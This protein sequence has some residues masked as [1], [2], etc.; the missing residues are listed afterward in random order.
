[1]YGCGSTFGDSADNH[2]V[3]RS[4]RYADIMGPAAEQPKGRVLEKVSKCCQVMRF[5]MAAG[6]EKNRSIERLIYLAR[7][8]LHYLQEG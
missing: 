6:V 4:R 8:C 1:M 3:E 5:A 7:C 2:R